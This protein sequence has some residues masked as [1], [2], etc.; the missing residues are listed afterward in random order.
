[1]SRDIFGWEA[2]TCAIDRFRRRGDLKK[3]YQPKSTGQSCDLTLTP[4]GWRKSGTHDGG[5]EDAP[6]VADEWRGRFGIPVVTERLLGTSMYIRQATNPARIAIESSRV[7]SSGVKS[8]RVELRKV[9]HLTS[10]VH[11]LS[12]VLQA[13]GRPQGVSFMIHDSS[14]KP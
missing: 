14:I 13:P 3:T 4:A 11:T 7:K 10:N 9:Q 8:S 6:T 1:M 12:G 5:H 2:V